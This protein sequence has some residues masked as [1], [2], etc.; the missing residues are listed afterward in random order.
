MNDKKKGLYDK[1]YVRR[2]DGSDVR[3]GEHEGFDYFVLDLTHDPYAIPAILTYADCCASEY[4]LLAEDLREIAFRH[5][6]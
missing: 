6:A 4:P 5:D 2:M 1:F 3:G